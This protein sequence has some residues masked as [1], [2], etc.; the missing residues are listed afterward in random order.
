MRVL[1]VAVKIQFSNTVVF[2]V[3]AAGVTLELILVE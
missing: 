3:V 1:Q 2:V